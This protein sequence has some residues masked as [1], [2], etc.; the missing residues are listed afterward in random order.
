MSGRAAQG[1]ASL[2]LILLILSIPSALAIY[3][4][5]GLAALAAAF[6]LTHPKH[7]GESLERQR[8][9]SASDKDTGGS[10]GI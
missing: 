6:W 9:V 1:I 7:V 2:L 8:Q 4:V 3:L 5:P 10:D